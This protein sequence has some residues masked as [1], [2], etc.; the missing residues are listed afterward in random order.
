MGW[1][2]HVKHTY[3]STYVYMYIYVVVSVSL[4]YFV[5]TVRI[6]QRKHVNVC[7]VF[8]SPVGILSHVIAIVYLGCGVEQ[9]LEWCIAR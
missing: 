3:V 6:Q 1:Q 4:L 7:I 9:G 8:S 2:L 5:Y